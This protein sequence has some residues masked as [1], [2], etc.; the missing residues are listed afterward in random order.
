MCTFLA[1]LSTNIFGQNLGLVLVLELVL[2]LVLGLVLGLGFGKYL[3]CT[4]V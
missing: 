3:H 1:L 4:K 2:E